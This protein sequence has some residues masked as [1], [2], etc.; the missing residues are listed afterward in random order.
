[1]LKENFELFEKTFLITGKA[2]DPRGTD[3]TRL[4]H[5]LETRNETGDVISRKYFGAY[6]AETNS[7]SGLCVGAVYTYTR[8]VNN[9]VV[10]CVEDLE[11]YFSDGSV[12]V[13][14]QNVKKYE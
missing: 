4:C 6:D 5:L 3:Y 14:K 13:T 7:F 8:D 12:G 1:M 10:K 2:F 9:Q 11:W